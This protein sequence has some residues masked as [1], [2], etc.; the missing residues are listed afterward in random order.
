MNAPWNNIKFDELS[1]KVEERLDELFE[2]A[3]SRLEIQ[4]QFDSGLIIDHLDNLNKIL[5]SIEPEDP[6]KQI[7]K[8]LKQL[9]HLKEIYKEDKYLLILTRLQINLCN[10]IKAH[11]EDAHPLTLKLLRSIFNNMCDIVSAKNMKKVD[12]VRIINKEVHRYNKLHELIKNR[13]HSI[14]HNK[15]K[16]LLKRRANTSGTLKIADQEK[17]QFDTK[18]SLMAQLIFEKAMSEIKSFIRKELE[19]FKNELQLDIINK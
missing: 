16:S 5:L 11:K 7:V 9:E 10:Y 17:D 12:T 4:K 2:E 19:K 1:L 18:E 15:A 6:D 14:K 8:V 13:H 3:A